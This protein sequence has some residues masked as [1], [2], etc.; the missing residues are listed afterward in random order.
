VFQAGGEVGYLFFDKI[1]LIGKL[2]VQK[3]G[4]GTTYTSYELNLIYKINKHL[5]IVSNVSDYGGFLVERKN[6]Y[7]GFAYTLGIS[8][9]Y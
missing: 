4:E 3:Y 8:L 7:D 6:V 2:K 1:Y 9:E 5:S